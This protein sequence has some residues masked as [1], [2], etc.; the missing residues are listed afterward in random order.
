M[1]TPLRLAVVLAV[2]LAAGP[3]LAQDDDTPADEAPVKVTEA[4]YATYRKIGYAQ[5][6]A[7]ARTFFDRAN[8]AKYEAEGA[9]AVKD[10]GWTK[11]R[12]DEVR[13]ALSSVQQ[14]VQGFEQHEI[15]K[16]DY[17][18]SISGYDKATIATARA[19]LKEIAEGPNDT[20]RAEA[21]VRAE[22]DEARAGTPPTIAGVQGTW[23]ID[24]DGSM[25]RILGPGAAPGITAKMRKDLE[26]SSYQF[27]PGDAIVATSKNPEGTSRVEKGTFRIDGHTIYFKAAGSKREQEL[28]A[29][30]DKGK[31]ILGGGMM[32]MLYKRK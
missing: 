5:A 10:A 9:R 19:H 20:A 8:A 16:A 31:L 1:P 7:S 27:G 15:E 25:A 17:D 28:E 30:M 24:I 14:T 26:G 6:L 21:Q 29:G 18:E 13:G 2:L 23:I 3:V 12:F 11:E 4:D 22:R 32:G